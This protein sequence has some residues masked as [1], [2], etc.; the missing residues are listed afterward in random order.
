MAPKAFQ[1]TALQKHRGTDAGAV[2]DAKSLNVE[3]SSFNFLWHV[4]T[5]LSLG[6][7]G[8]KLEALLGSIDNIVL[9]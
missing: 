1:H 4:I 9:E 2:V 3:Y 5:S 8:S 7:N 6:F